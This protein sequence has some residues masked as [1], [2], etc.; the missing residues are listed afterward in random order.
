MPEVM[1]LYP[2]LQKFPGKYIISPKR[3]KQKEEEFIKDGGMLIFHLPMF[4]IVD[5]DNYK[6][7]LDSDFKSF[8]YDYYHCTSRK[9]FIS[10][11]I[12][13]SSCLA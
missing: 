13:S 1:K 2:H 6:Q 5:K 11:R 7:F 3:W 12:L 9:R 8:S 10:F 4:H